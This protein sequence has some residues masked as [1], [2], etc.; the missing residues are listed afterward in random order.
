[1]T[2]IPDDLEPALREIDNALKAEG[3][4]PH[5]RG[6]RA[7][8]EF[9]K[10]FHV[11]LPLVDLPPGASVENGVPA[12]VILHAGYTKRIHA[13]FSEVYGERMK[14]DFSANAKVAVLADGDM[15]E[16]RIPLMFGGAYFVTSRVLEPEASAFSRGPNKVNP[17]ASLTHITAS[18]LAHFSDADL[19]EVYGLFV[20]GLD[21]RDAFKRFRNEHQLFVEAETDWTS[22]VGHLTAQN[23]NFGQSRWSTLQMCEKFMKGLI[24][25]IGSGDPKQGHNLGALHDELAKTIYGMDLRHLIPELC[26]TAQVRYGETL[27]TREQAYAAHKA[28]LL[29]VRA[30][31]SVGRENS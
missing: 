23:P 26:C 6:I 20:V 12:E 24:N 7:V 30:L 18:R 8:I 28:A 11:S 19:Q 25:V 13:W 15:W 17:C 16:L 14:V 3:V 10:R 29:L 5:G 1:M 27:S 31:G 21:V 2:G 22:A 4:P 9:G